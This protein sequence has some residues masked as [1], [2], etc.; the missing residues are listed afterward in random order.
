[1]AGTE[2]GA[3]KAQKTIKQK[4]GKKFLVER[5][6]KAGQKGAADGVVKGY[7][8]NPELAR[9]AGR[10]GALARWGKKE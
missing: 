3:A 10:K 2:A 6:R 1:M 9:E 5:A 4:K 8:T 7:A